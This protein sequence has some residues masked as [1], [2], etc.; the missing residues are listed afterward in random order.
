[1]LSVSH[2]NKGTIDQRCINTFIYLREIKGDEHSLDISELSNTRKHASRAQPTATSL[3]LSKDASNYGRSPA[4]VK[5]SGF[6]AAQSLVHLIPFGVPYEYTKQH[7]PCTS[8]VVD[9]MRASSGFPGPPSNE[10]SHIILRHTSTCKCGVCTL[11]GYGWSSERGRTVLYRN[12]VGQTFR[13][14]YGVLQFW[15]EVRRW[16]QHRPLQLFL[17]GH[18]DRDRWKNDRKLSTIVSSP[19]PTCICSR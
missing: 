10:S 15:P 3:Q 14:P 5:T 7:R 12:H 1:M 11:A 13:L 18:D 4:N 2:S 16:D 6:C 19:T 9:A 17:Y 8:G